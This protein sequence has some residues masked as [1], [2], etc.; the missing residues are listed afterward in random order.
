MINCST[1]YPLTI[2]IQLPE[3]IS[4]ELNRYLTLQQEIIFRIERID[5]K[6]DLIEG[7]I[8]ERSLRLMEKHVQIRP[9]ADESEVAEQETNLDNFF[10]N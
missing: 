9:T 4:D 2:S 3:V 1:N 5:Y 7:A 10:V 6:Q 8:N